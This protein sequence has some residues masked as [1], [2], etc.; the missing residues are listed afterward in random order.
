GEVASVGRINSPLAAYL[1]E[2]THEIAEPEAVICAYLN[3]R[4][5]PNDVVLAT[6][7][8]LVIQFY[9]KLRVHGSLQGT[10]G[11][12][13]PDWIVPRQEPDG[14]WWGGKEEALEQALQDID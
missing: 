2:I 10:A 8:D 13:T 3:T 6:Y 1:Y 7:D 5:Q 9:T 14:V 12:G 4:A 11:K